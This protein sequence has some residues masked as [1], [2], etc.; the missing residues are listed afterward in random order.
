MKVRIGNDIRFNLTLKGNFDQANIKQLKCY[1]INTSIYDYDPFIHMC[2][3][4]PG[5]CGDCCGGCCGHRLCHPI[6]GIDTHLCGEPGYHTMPCNAHH[7]C[8]NT[9][10]WHHFDYCGCLHHCGH[11]KYPY[12]PCDPAYGEGPLRPNYLHCDCERCCGIHH[13][14]HQNH[15]DHCNYCRY[16]FQDCRARCHDGFC[17]K[18]RCCDVHPDMTPY[19]RPGYNDFIAPHLDENFRY[20]ASSRTLS[21]KNRIQ[22]FFPARDQFLCGDYK[23][24]VVVVKYESGWGRCDLHTYTIDYGTVVTLVDDPTGVTG[25]ITIDL[26][27]NELMDSEIKD[28]Y[29]D[30]NSNHLYIN[31]GDELNIGGR[32]L[33]DTIYKIN[34]GLENGSFVSYDP[35]TWAES[36][37]SELSFES[38]DTSSLL[39]N[40]DGRLIGQNVEQTTDVNVTV[41]VPGAAVLPYT[42]VVTVLSGANV[43][44]IG[45]S[46]TNNVNNLKLS[47]LNQVNNLFKTHFLTNSTEG[48]YLW[49]CSRVPV[50]D[51]DSADIYARMSNTFDVPLE[52]KGIKEGYN[53]YLCPNPLIATKFDITVEDR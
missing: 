49:I 15:H 16:G 46:T 20:L 35:A 17:M 52:Y 45:F 30:P 53:C 10:G 7:C 18:G 12:T 27:N 51:T 19:Y 2:K 9:P 24:V 28:I 43:D 34:V 33:H 4:F 14:P 36:G 44:Y 13:G 37:Y 38:S 3:R 8:D 23:L 11:L 47:D 50:Q 39:V 26:D 25:N 21:G 29:M 1:L 5:P 22:T 31:A 32:D 48:A 41:S 40:E 42:F 6:V